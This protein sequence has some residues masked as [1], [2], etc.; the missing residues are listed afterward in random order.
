MVFTWNE[1]LQT[2][3]L[4]NLTITTLYIWHTKKK[5]KNSPCF[6]NVFYMLLKCTLSSHQRYKLNIFYCINIQR[7]WAQVIAILDSPPSDINNWYN[8]GSNWFSINNINLWSVLTHISLA[9]HFWDIGKQCRPRTRRLIRV[10]TVC[11]QDFYQKYDKNEKVHQIPL[12]EKWTRP[13]DKDGKI[14]LANMG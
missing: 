10:Y 12:N 13:I 3:Q 11:S 5:K 1:Y 14:H 7:D 9:S 4:N 6:R 8:G 2:I